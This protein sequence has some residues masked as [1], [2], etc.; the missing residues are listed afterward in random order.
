MP[1]NASAE[2]D[3]HPGPRAYSSLSA[4]SRTTQ[5]AAAAAAA[6]VWF[7]VVVE[8]EEEEVGS[9]QT[10]VPGAPVEVSATLI[11]N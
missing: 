8:E 11:A 6:A 9:G 3:E 2:E 1:T 10:A 5:A 4:G 7:L